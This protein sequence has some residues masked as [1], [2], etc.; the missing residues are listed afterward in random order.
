M[1][2]PHKQ[3]L[4]FDCGVGQSGFFISRPP[5]TRLDSSLRSSEPGWFKHFRNCCDTKKGKGY[6]DSPG[7]FRREV[8]GGDR[9]AARDRVPMRCFKNTVGVR[10]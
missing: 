5:T 8:I 2:I 9:K 1:R 7:N 4:V 3:S 10:D 6:S